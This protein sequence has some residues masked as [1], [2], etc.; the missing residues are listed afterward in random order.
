MVCCSQ[1]TRKLCWYAAPRLCVQILHLIDGRLLEAGDEE[2]LKLP[3]DNRVCTAHQYVLFTPN[4]FWSLVPVV[5]VF[6]QY[7]K[8]Y[9]QFFYK[10]TQSREL[11][12]KDPA[13]K[14]RRIMEESDRYFKEN[15]INQLDKISNRPK[16]L[17][18]VRVSSMAFNF[19]FLLLNLFI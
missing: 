13:E 18:W 12:N 8:L 7:D 9:K 1:C 5:I 14:K 16:G 10:L 19:S 4:F 2:F 3:F 15:C 11:A 17:K 6:T